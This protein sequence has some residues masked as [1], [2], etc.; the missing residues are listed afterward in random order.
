[1]NKKPTFAL[2]LL[3][4]LWLF[5]ASAMAAPGGGSSPEEKIA[6]GDEKTS[7]FI[8]KVLGEYL[9]SRFSN[10]GI[11][12]K[13]ADIS[14]SKTEKIPQNYDDYSFNVSRA[15][16]AGNG[17]SGNLEFFNNSQL[18]KSIPVNAKAEFTAEVVVATGKIVKGVTITEDMVTVNKLKVNANPDDLCTDIA[19][20][21][22]QVAARNIMA[23]RAIERS[24]LIAP[25]DVKAGDLIVI[26]AE[27]GDI[28]MTA[29]GIAKKDGTAGEVIPVI[30]VRS[31]KKLF[32]RVVEPGIVKVAF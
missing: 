32:G 27:S 5:P 14:Y 26:L 30:N 23:G 11:E 1:M 7:S 12:W 25:A 31:N 2:L 16:K 4:S 24:N 9:D 21:V 6:A 28:K 13:I 17:I 22:G 29:R 18:I 19:I 15:L 8:Q 20:V 10:S 3:A